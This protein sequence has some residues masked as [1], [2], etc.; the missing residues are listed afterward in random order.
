MITATVLHTLSV[1]AP[2]DAEG[3]PVKLEGKTTPGLISYVI[4]SSL[5]YRIALM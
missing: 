1:S 4:L 5:I 2:L 3:N